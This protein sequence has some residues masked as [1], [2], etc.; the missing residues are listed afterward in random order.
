MSL[1]T[2]ERIK[3]TSTKSPWWCAIVSFAIVIGL[4]ILRVT[5]DRRESSFSFADI[6]WTQTGVKFGMVVIMVMAALTVTTEVR[7]NTLRTTF[8]AVPKRT[9]ALLA[10]AVVV[11][12]TAGVVGEIAAWIAWV[13]GHSLATS[14]IKGHLTFV[15]A[16]DYRVVYGVGLVFFIVALL[17]MGVGLLIR[18]S[19]G[20]ISVMI[21]WAILLENLV[22]L[23][24]QVGADIQQWL[25]F[26]NIDQFLNVGVT[27]TAVRAGDVVTSWPLSPWGSLGYSALWSVVIFTAGVVVS[28]KRDA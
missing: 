12:V 1:L 3:F 21:V 28:K 11:A 22:T 15:N 9:P 20:A 8:L 16:A 4:S 24:G 13:V 5:T 6:T 23:L 18:Q 25:P 19:A 10:K 17:A 26:S 27:Q 14:G 7:F 2:A